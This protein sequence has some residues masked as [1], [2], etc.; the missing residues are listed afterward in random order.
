MLAAEHRVLVTVD[1]DSGKTCS[2]PVCV[3]TG[4]GE[5]TAM[6]PCIVP[7]W[8]DIIEVY[9]IYGHIWLYTLRL[10]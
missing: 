6:S 4:N 1:N 2:V 10:N 7:S 8:E 5:L 9:Y 3:K